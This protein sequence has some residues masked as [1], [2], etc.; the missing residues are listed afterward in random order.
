MS[1]YEHPDQTPHSA[2]SDL[3]LRYLPLSHKKDARLIRVN[4]CFE[5]TENVKKILA[6][7]ANLVI[8]DC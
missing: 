5:R 7:M 4:S 6:V 3:S 8:I 1:T 2:V